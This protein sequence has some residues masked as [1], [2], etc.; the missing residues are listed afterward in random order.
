MLSHILTNDPS[1]RLY[2]ALVKTK[3]AVA[4]HSEAAAWHDPGMLFIV[5]VV[6][7]DGSREGVRDLLLE[8]VEKTMEGVSAAE[9][10]RARRSLLSQREQTA[11]QTAA[12]AMEL[13]EWAAQGDWRFYF[14]NRDRLENVPAA[15]VKTVASKYLKAN[16]RTVGLFIPTKQAERIAVPATPDYKALV[17]GYKGRET[18]AKA[19]TFD[20]SPENIEKST[21]WT[22]LPSGLKV[23]LLP[24]KTNGDMVTIVLNLNYGDAESLKGFDAACALMPRLLVRGT[25]KMTFQQINDELNKCKSGL[26]G[27][28]NAGVVS[29]QVEAKRQHLP[30]VLEILRQMLREPAL[31]ASELELFSAN[32]LTYMEAARKDPASQ[33]TQ[34]LSRRLSRFPKGDIRYE[35]TLDEGVE[36]FKN[37]TLE[38]VQ[39]LYREYLGAE[40]GELAIVGDFDAGETL[41][42]FSTMLGDWKASKPY[43]RLDTSVEC[44]FKAVREVIEIADKDNANYNAGL[45][46]AM[47]SKHPDWAALA[48]A[49]R[50]FGGGPTSR[51][52][53]RLRE[54][55]GL[56]Y[57]VSSSFSASSME[58]RA[59]LFISAIANPAN[60]PKTEKYIMEELV[61]FWK[62]GVTKDELDRELASFIQQQSVLLAADG[63]LASTL[64]ASLYTGRKVTEFL[65]L[66]RFKAL[67]PEALHEAFRRHIDPAQ[68]VV[69]VA[70]DFAKQLSA[71]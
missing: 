66:G 10:E 60:M 24:K 16:N 9:V 5:A 6:P 55:E 25:K 23:A 49:N 54:K 43:A 65:E 59:S 57:N 64:T 53:Q 41:K 38:Q 15:D 45:M 52:F 20:P 68:L 48:M 30:A 71:K 13:S 12:V 2:E 51:L 36:M 39:T 11:A 62:D 7:S 19:A 21:T 44:P 4:V 32:M 18:A 63:S 31:S 8:V 50:I 47:D 61:R 33:A 67:T 69:V 3:K 17:S 34:A 1:G 28:G 58:K 14:L 27:S 42:A 40:H 70:G 26:V 46:F 35:P 56:C 37:V 22:A 29:F